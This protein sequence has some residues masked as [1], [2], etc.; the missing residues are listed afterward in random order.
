MSY[1]GQILISLL[2]IGFLLIVVGIVLKVRPYKFRL[3]D[4]KNGFTLEGLALRKILS[5]FLRFLSGNTNSRRY[6]FS[7]RVISRSET[8]M[9][10]N[11]LY[12]LKLVSVIV[13]TV[14]ALLVSFT[15]ADIVKLSIMSKP[16]EGFQIFQDIS[17]QDYS[18]NV[19]LY[20]AVVGRIGEETLKKLDNTGKLE[21]IK[22]VLPA[23][24][25]TGERAIIE[26]NAA[27]IA[28]TFD[29]VT[30][31]SP[32]NLQVIILIL[33][34][35][36]FPELVLFIKRLLLGNRYRKEVIK[37]ENIFE[38]LG[39]IRNFKTINVIEEMAKASKS[40]R[41]H[42]E[43]CRELFKTEKE[44]AL[45]V[46]KVSVK[47]SRFSR[48]VDIL[49]VYS[50]TDKKLALQ[51]MERNRLE[52]EEEILITAEEDIDLVDLIAF[53]SIVPILLQLANLLLKPMLDMIYEAFRFI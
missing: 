38:L 30:K 50:M 34:S 7:Q 12:F 49:R 21:E 17:I 39:S 35:F 26:E 43:N 33:S 40:Y 18:R 31:I 36:W 32:L 23:L 53:I 4:V 37:L 8:E 41:K 27:G 3:L 14:I 6:R 15:N 2:V 25:G 48:L 13:V 52:K 24:M 11:A 1:I 22:N 45:E 29:I 16:Q 47:N 19:A 51:I 42:L 20:K 9:S 28:K 5:P 10:V 44:Q 46:L